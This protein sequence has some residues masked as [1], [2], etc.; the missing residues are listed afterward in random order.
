MPIPCTKCQTPIP[1]GLVHCPACGADA[2][3]DPG[4]EA[5]TQPMMPS[6]RPT[7]RTVLAQLG[8]SLGTNYQVRVVDVASPTV[9]DESDGTFTVQ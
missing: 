8:E 1:D 5:E 9:L 3:T 4:P 2:P 6:A 7:A